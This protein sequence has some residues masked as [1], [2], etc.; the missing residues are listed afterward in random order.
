ML[1]LRNNIPDGPE[2]KSERGGYEMF[3]P[4]L[5]LL[6]ARPGGPLLEASW[7]GFFFIHPARVTTPESMGTAAI[8]SGQFSIAPLRQTGCQQCS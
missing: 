8:W 7:K 3:R 2:L 1:S 4:V 6:K 5:K